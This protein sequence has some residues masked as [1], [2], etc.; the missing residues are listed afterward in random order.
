MG[1]SVLKQ[2][3][4]P[5]EMWAR[6]FRFLF[7][8]MNVVWLAWLP[9]SS[10]SNLG[11]IIATLVGRNYRLLGEISNLTYYFVPPLLVVYLCHFLSFRVYARVRAVDWSAR[12]VVSRAML[13]NSLSIIPFFFLI[14]AVNSFA[15]GTS[16]AG[17]FLVLAI[18]CWFIWG[19]LASK[20]FNRSMYAVTSGELRDRVF[21]LA[22]RA[23]VKLNQIY[24]LPEAKAQ[25]SNAFARGDNAVMLTGSLLKHLSKREVDGIMA[26]EIGHLKEKHPQRNSWIMITVIVV[27]NIVGMVVA[28]FIPFELSTPVILSLSLV[29]AILVLHFLSRSNERHADTIAIS[30]TGDPEAFIS[31]L[32]KLDQLNLMSVHSGGWGESLENASAHPATVAGLSET[33]RH[34]RSA[35]Y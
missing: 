27:T 9:I 10:L 14:L 3:D 13:A 8:L 29:A 4:R 28:A 26:H 5:A 6:Y 11:E 20:A 1:W 33:S 18:A 22:G 15:S 16:Y 24:V 2:Q 23:G 21:E 30:L 31:G 19:Q 17:V 25:R 7:R 32:A 12:E 34:F 35:F